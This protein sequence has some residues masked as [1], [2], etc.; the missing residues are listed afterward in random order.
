MRVALVTPDLRPSSGGPAVNVP[1]LAQA[2][3][4]LGLDVE[5][6]TVGEVPSSGSN[7]R[8]VGAAPTALRH[9]GRSR[10]LRRNLLAYSADIVHAHCL[11]MLPLAYAVTAARA[12]GVP[13]VISPRGMLAPWSLRR[14]RWKKALASRLVHPGAFEAAAGWH[15]TSGREAQ[16]LQALGFRQPICVSPNG[17]EP[18]ASDRAEVRAHYWSLAPELA[19]K[20]IL[21]FYSRFHSKKR[22]KELLADFASLAGSRLEWHLLAVGIPEEFSVAELRSVAV[23]LGIAHRA[24]ILDGSDMRKPYSLAE[25][26]ALPTHDENFGSVVAEAL[27]EGVPVITTTGTPWQ[28]LNEHRAGRWVA[29]PDFRGELGALMALENEELRGAGG[30]GRA[31]VLSRFGWDAAAQKLKTFYETLLANQRSTP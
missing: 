3:A 4:G 10:E 28:G 21:L 7:P 16:D 30:R 8:F 13:L 12:R 24:T 17:V 14:S 20:R 22:I 2:L 18:D 23:T 6:H 11:W 15:A 27:A 19:G 5:L 31:W 26:V 9:L 29:I 1:R 25:L